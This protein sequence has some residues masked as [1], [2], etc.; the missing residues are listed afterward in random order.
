MARAYSTFKPNTA[1]P[2]L[3]KSHDATCSR[4][5]CRIAGRMVPLGITQAVRLST[6]K[7]YLRD[8]A[9]GFEPT[10]YMA[11]PPVRMY[12]PEEVPVALRVAAAL[13]DHDPRTRTYKGQRATDT[14]MRA[15]FARALGKED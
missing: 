11:P 1:N 12:G 9:L 6:R 8:K 7:T 3:C 13:T 2:T 14:D 4:P 10:A 15:A 5:S